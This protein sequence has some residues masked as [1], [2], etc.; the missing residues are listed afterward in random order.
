MLQMLALG[1]REDVTVVETDYCMFGVPWRKRT[2]FMY[3]YVD[4]SR[5]ARKCSSRRGFCDRT[6]HRHVQLQGAKD[7][8]LLTKLA[9]PYLANLCKLLASSFSSA[10]CE[11]VVRRLRKLTNGSDT[12]AAGSLLD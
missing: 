11:G 8:Q 12:E 5:I 7:G 3:A 2:K 6:G 4:L 1:R 10:L 9:E